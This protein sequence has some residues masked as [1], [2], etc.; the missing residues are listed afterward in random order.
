MDYLFLLLTA[1]GIT[2]TLVWAEILDI[3]K[4]RPFLYKSEFL[5]KLL[6]C[7]FCTSFYVGILLTICFIPFGKMWLLFP[8]S[9]CPVVFLW[10]RI[11]IFLDEK[12]IEL[13]N[14][15]QGK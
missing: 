3:L 9:V 7:S 11:V 5:K 6:K 10:D 15:R 13:E 14:K 1:C 8:L 2:Y 12:I 4:I